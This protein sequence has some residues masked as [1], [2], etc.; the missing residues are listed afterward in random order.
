MSHSSISGQSLGQTRYVDPHPLPIVISLAAS[1]CWSL[2]SISIPMTWDAAL[3]PIYAPT[4]PP[5]VLPSMASPLPLHL[6]FLP[7]A[8][9]HPL[10]AFLVIVLTTHTQV[11]IASRAHEIKQDRASF[12]LKHAIWSLKDNRLAAIGDR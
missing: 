12:K 7:S 6:H 10:S 11:M 1:P 9:G 2:A 8:A 5:N 3:C 4:P